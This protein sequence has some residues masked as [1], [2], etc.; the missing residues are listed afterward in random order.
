[1][2]SIDLEYNAIIYKS[3]VERKKSCI[4]S[5]KLSEIQKYFVEQKK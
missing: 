1:M 4:C 2:K 5:E 3:F